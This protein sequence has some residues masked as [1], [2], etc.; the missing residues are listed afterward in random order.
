MC[1]LCVGDAW[2]TSAKVPVGN[3]V[4]AGNGVRLPWAGWVVGGAYE[5]RCMS[6]MTVDGGGWMGGG[7]G[8]AGGEGCSSREQAT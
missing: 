7:D 1:T 4:T 2:M 5:K 3:L 8:G 6:Q